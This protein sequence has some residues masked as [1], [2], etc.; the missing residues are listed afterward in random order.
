MI[1]SLT[2]YL[3]HSVCISFCIIVFFSHW[4]SLSFVTA[5]LSLSQSVSLS[6][7]VFFFNSSSL[8]IYTSALQSVS[9]S[10][11][12]SFS[13]PPSLSIFLSLSFSHSLSISSFLSLVLCDLS[14]SCNSFTKK[15][16]QRFFKGA[17]QNWL[18]PIPVQIV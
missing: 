7:F 5:F 6:L 16:N 1:A 2:I 8:Y 15:G 4:L 3:Y 17:Q 13:L 9:L 11:S 10:V 14:K 12:L 18:N